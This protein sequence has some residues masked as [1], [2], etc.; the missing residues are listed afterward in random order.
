MNANPFT[1]GHL[2]LVEKAAKENDLLHL[3]MVSEDSSLVPY[4]ARKKL[5]MNGTKHLKNIVYHDSG[6]YIISNATFPSYFQKDE[7]AVIRGHAL[8]DLTI[9]KSI[10]ETLSINKR[11]VGEERSSQVTSIY[12]K[13]M[14]DEL[15]KSGVEC[16]VVPRKEC[17]EE[18]ISA[19]KVRSLIH[20]GNIEDTKN[21]LPKTSYEFFK[22]SEGKAIIERIQKAEDVIHY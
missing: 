4:E 13:I 8:L 3:F 16:I 7:E 12:N 9:F 6:A 17:D 2:Y 21:L 1:L 19:S 5:I 20:S 15:P 10:A 18:P 14:A 22:S 11:Y